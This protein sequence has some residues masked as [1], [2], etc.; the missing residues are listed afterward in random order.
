MITQDSLKFCFED[1]TAKECKD[2]AYGEGDYVLFELHS[3]NAGSYS[4]AERMHY[5]ETIAEEAAAS[6]QL[7]LDMDDFLRLYDEVSADNKE[8]KH[9]R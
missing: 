7:F 6:G 9:L 1:L 8:F 4:Q 3:F 2:I 5:D